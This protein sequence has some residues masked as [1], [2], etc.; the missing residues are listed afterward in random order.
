VPV[1]NRFQAKA[2]PVPLFIQFHRLIRQVPERPVET[3]EWK[4]LLLFT[5]NGADLSMPGA[6]PVVADLRKTAT[7]VFNGVYLELK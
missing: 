7:P 5:G 1:K 3:R 4:I 6:E 2:P